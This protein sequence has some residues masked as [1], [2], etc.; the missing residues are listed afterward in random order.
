MVDF[1]SFFELFNNREL[2]IGTISIVLIG[3]SLFSEKIRKAY[4]NIVRC[5]FNP[6][7]ILPLIAYFIYIAYLAYLSNNYLPLD[8]SSFKTITLWTLFVGLFL[9]WKFFD[10]KNAFE[11]FFTVFK[12]SF[13]AIIVLEFVIDFYVFSFITELIIVSII[14]LVAFIEVVSSIKSEDKIVNNLSNTILSAVGIL[15][16][17]IAAYYVMTDFMALITI[18][19]TISFIL[20][21]LLTVA[22]LPFIFVLLITVQ[23]EGI[24]RKFSRSNSSLNRKFS[25]FLYVL[26]Q[27]NL[28]LNKLKNLNSSGAYYISS[29]LESE[30]ISEMYNEFRSLIKK[31]A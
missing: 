21:T 25:A 27:C 31:E 19:N 23:Y 26:W 18:E 13:A 17:I 16:L 6:L 9:I 1:T 12:S 20:P 3:S 2:A 22:T 30:N 10:S 15:L 29:S 5:F 8:I 14:S 7:I 24:L 4:L 11:L 28:N